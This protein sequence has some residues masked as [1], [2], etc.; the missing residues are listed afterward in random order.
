MKFT[1]MKSLTFMLITLPDAVKDLFL[2]ELLLD[3]KLKTFD[4]VSACQSINPTLLQKSPLN[5]TTLNKIIWFL[6]P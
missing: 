6:T 5:N 4:Q 1:V 3:R 2:S